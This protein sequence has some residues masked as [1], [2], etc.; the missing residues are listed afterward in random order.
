MD[1]FLRNLLTSSGGSDLMVSDKTLSDIAKSLLV[2]NPDGNPKTLREKAGLLA[3]INL[4]GIMDAFF[5]VTLPESQ[6]KALMN[7][8]EAADSKPSEE[9]PSEVQ[10]DA[11]EAGAITPV[12]PQSPAASDPVMSLFSML[13]RS[14]FGTPGQT[15]APASQGGDTGKAAPSEGLDPRMLASLLSVVTAFT[16][17]LKPRAA[18]GEKG[19]EGQGNEAGRAGEPGSEAPN[20][21]SPLQQA[22]GF[23]PKILTLLLNIIASMDF[24]RQKNGEGRQPEPKAAEP[25]TTESK[26]SEPKLPDRRNLEQKTPVDPKAEELRPEPKAP[27]AKAPEWKTAEAKVADPQAAEPKPTSSIPVEQKPSEGGEPAAKAD[28]A[29]NAVP[30]D[31]L[32]QLIRKRPTTRRPYHKPGTGIYRGWPGVPVVQ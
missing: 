10:G 13:A 14:L 28:R 15:E 24:M 32:A 3:L 9:K 1:R 26:A 7:I 29:A 22:L 31:P 5:G 2:Q 18:E 27:E 4:L 30:K 16:K 21:P 25:K 20:K 19:S 12:Q 8:K 17:A 6:E 11:G 23:D